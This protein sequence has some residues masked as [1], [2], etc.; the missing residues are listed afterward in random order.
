LAFLPQSTSSDICLRALV[1]IRRDLRGS[2]VFLRNIV[3]DSILAD[4]PS[5]MATDVAELIDKH[6][7]ESA[8][9]L[10]GDYVDFKTDVKVGSHW[11]EV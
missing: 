6:M 2:G 7:V 4:T 11:G 10:I 1:R 8:Q 3:H 5:D 9:E